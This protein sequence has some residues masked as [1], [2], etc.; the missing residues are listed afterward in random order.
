MGGSVDTALVAAQ[1]EAIVACG[2]LG[3]MELMKRCFLDSGFISSQT[4]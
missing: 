3:V 1:W 4:Q 2:L